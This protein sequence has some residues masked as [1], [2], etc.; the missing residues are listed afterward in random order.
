MAVM[1]QA[2]QERNGARLQGYIDSFAGLDDLHDL[3]LQAAEAGGYLAG[4]IEFG[5]CPAMVAEAWA[6]RI[7]QAAAKRRR[8]LNAKARAHGI[9]GTSFQRLNALALQGE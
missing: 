1:S 6:E 7:K 3:R 8:A 4:M 5:G 9:P 2:E